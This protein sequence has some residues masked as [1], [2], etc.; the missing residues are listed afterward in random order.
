MASRLTDKFSIAL[1]RLVSAVARRLTALK[2]GVNASWSQC[3]V[4]SLQGVVG[5]GFLNSSGVG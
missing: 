3:M 2:I 1:D 5:V 4:S